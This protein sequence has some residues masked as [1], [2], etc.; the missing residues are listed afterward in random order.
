[1]SVSTKK[2]NKV[3]LFLR[4]LGREV[5][6]GKWSAHCLETD[7]VGYGDTFNSALKKL[8]ELTEMQISFAIY[9]NQPALLD[10]PAPPEVFELYNTEHRV[11]LTRATTSTPKRHDRVVTSIQLPHPSNKSGFALAQA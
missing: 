5:E 7:L 3:S 2:V 10:H 6:G 11:E 9:K 1:M 4:V 8:F